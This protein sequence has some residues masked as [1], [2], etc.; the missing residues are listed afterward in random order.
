[1]RRA[2]LVA[3]TLLARVASAGTVTEVHYVM[4]TYFRITAEH[5]DENGARAALRQCFASTRHLEELFSRFDPA[6]ELSQV[7]ATSAQDDRV[8]VSPEMAALLRR[9][10]A[11]QAATD[12]AFDVGVG[13]LTQLWRNSAEWPA[14]PVIDAARQ[15][16]GAGALALR[17][18]SLIRRP[19]VI[20]DLDG[21][22][23]GWAVDRCAV[24]LRAAGITRALLSLGESS[25][26]ALGA[27]R[28]AHGW[29]VTLRDLSGDGALGTLTLRD[30]AVSVSA[31]LGHERQIGRLRVGHIVD[32]RSGQPLTT[33]AMAV[34]VAPSATDAEAFSKALLIVAP[35]S[36]R[37]S[38]WITGALLVRLDG[39]QPMGRIAFAAFKMPQ[40][41]SATAEPL[42]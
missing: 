39:M 4:G 21:I 7:N 6:S 12:G 11:L 17:D 22:A 34:V 20:I 19:G 1:M 24:Q 41:I 27:P 33:P 5:D 3:L 16:G 2:A 15:T 29:T 14:A 32:P 9:A 10:I 31:V 30:Q 35:A 13:A 26:Y 23:K 42:R 40:E 38:A 28:G 37:W 36:K 8:T 18:A 25:L